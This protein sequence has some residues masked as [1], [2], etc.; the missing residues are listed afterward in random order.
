[1]N[2]YQSLKRHY[3]F[4]KEE[5]AILKELQP[6]MQANVDAFLDAFYDYIWGFGKTAQYFKN[7]EILAYHK[8]K[9]KEWY[10][11]LFCGKYDLEYFLYLYKI[12][13]THVRIG[14]PTH[15]VNSA[16][17][18]VRALRSKLWKRTL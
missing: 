13:E 11:N 5:E 3:R 16:F 10:I 9:I 18:F 7:K 15:Y 14:L 1:M 17:T 2:D 12:G 6:K 8:S 4:T